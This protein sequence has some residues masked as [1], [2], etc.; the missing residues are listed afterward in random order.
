MSFS[1]FLDDYFDDRAAQIQQGC[2]AKITNIDNESMRADV[3]PLL[4]L[5][6]SLNEETDFPILVD[7]PILFLYSDG[8]YIRP[9]Y[10][11]HDY[12]WLGFSTY[13]TYNS[14]NG[15]TRTANESLF[16]LNNAC[17]ISGIALNNFSNNKFSK[18][19]I[20]IGSDN[21]LIHFSKSEITINEGTDYAVKYNALKTALDQLKS[22][23]DAFVTIFNAHTGHG[24]GGAP[25]TPASNTTADMSSSKVAE[26]R[27]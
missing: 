27:L 4:K 12:V 1:I 8:Y 24:T 3:K 25:A 9:N 7:V 20:L 11:I 19:G 14:L 6:N 10:A 2:V 18:D 5:K 21:S 23:F 13:D 26:V 15:E 17:I 16:K 22:D